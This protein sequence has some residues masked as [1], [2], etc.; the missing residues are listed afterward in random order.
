MVGGGGIL[1]IIF[2]FVLP[3]YTESYGPISA[4]QNAI[5]SPYAIWGILALIVLIAVVV[6]WAL[7]LFSPQT[8]IPTTQLG[9]EMTRA[10]LA[11]LAL[12]LLLIKLI[13]HTG[14]WGF[15]FYVD[16]I[17]AIVVVYGAYMI[18]QGKSTPVKA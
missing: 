14:N 3:W 16:V 1:L 4:S 2:L 15:G 10:A 13:A 11:G 7:A 5:S 12:L 18:A 6:D 9:R 8:Q 17:L